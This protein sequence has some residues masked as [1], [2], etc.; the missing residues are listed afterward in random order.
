MLFFAYHR[1]E[2][3]LAGTSLEAVLAFLTDGHDA[4]SGEDAVVWHGGRVAAVLRSSGEVIRFDA[5]ATPPPDA[6]TA[7]DAAS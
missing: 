5:P 3:L 4:P 7:E 1:D 2:Y 6:E